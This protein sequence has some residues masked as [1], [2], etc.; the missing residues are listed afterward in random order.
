MSIGTFEKPQ[1]PKQQATTNTRPRT[2]GVTTESSNPSK[3]LRAS[4]RRFENYRKLLMLQESIR[5]DTTKEHG[6]GQHAWY[7]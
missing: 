5:R 1:I 3:L 2:C 4:L 6:G 7:S